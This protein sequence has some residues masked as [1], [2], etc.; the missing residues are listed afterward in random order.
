MMGAAH[1]MVL[2]IPNPE[3]QIST[4]FL[5]NRLLGLVIRKSMWRASQSGFEK[6]LIEIKYVTE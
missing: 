3:F 1:H 4:N 5:C 6:A 2:L